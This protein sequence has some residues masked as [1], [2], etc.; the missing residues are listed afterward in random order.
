MDFFDALAFT[1]SQIVTKLKLWQN[2]NCDKTQNVTKLKLWPSSK[3]QIVTKLKKSNCDKTQKLKLWQNINY[4]QYQFMKKDT[5]E[6][7]FSRNILTPW[8]PMR[9]SL[10]SFSWF[11]QFF[12]MGLFPRDGNWPWVIWLL[13]KVWIVAVTKCEEQCGFFQLIM[14][15]L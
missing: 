5:S 4:D 11:S 9:C 6:W 14:G 2:S 7:S 15:N 8:Q 13:K 10:G 12:H 3:T 1:K